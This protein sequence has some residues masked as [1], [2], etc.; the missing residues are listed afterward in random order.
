MRMYSPKPDRCREDLAACRALLRHGSRSF[1]VASLLLP[2]NVREPASVLYAF[3]RLADDAVDIEARK[4]ALAHLR[5]RLRLAYLGR[6]LSS[7]ID[8]ALAQVVEQHDIPS[9]LPEALLQGLEWDA[10]GVRYETLGHL[11]AYAARVA[12]S[13]GAMMAIL[14][15]RRQPEA[16]ARAC[17]LGVAMQLT[18]IARDVGE[19]ARM[20]RLYL[21]GQWMRE[22]GLDP[23]QWLARPRFD[24]A[25]AGVVDRLLV[26]ADGLYDRARSGVDQLPLSCRPGIHAAR[27]I[28]S[29]IGREVARQGFDSMSRRAVVPGSRKAALLAGA[30][31]ASCRP[32]S[33]DP[34]APLAS[35][36]FLVAAAVRP[37]MT[38]AP[39]PRWRLTRRMVWLLE[40]FERLE[41]REQA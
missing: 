14:M 5:E 38:L 13:V 3:C 18:N 35:T 4:D 39:V 16:L 6:P 41:R 32:R 31:A 15:Q 22:A 33:A 26:A 27:L 21:P 20:G 29:E 10:T 19:D 1:F 30:L 36:R 7:P 23:D 34:A 9:A 40:L 8:R 11:E 25:L 37:P 28:Y 2:R 12:G 17:D 24:A